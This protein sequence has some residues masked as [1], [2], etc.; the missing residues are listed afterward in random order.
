MNTVQSIEDELQQR[1]VLQFKQKLAYGIGH[2]LNDVCASMWFTYLL[3]YYEKILL[4]SATNAGLVLLIGQ[5]ADALATPFVGLHSDIED[6]FW[7]CQYGKRKTW[8]LIGTVCV[9]GTFPFMFSQC[10]GC[11]MSHQWAQLVYYTVFVCI[12]QFGWAAVQISHLS[13]IPELTALEKER[14]ALI[15]IRYT[16]TVFSNVLVYSVTWAVLHITSL[17]TTILFHMF[18]KEYSRSS[19][20]STTGASREQSQRQPSSPVSILKNRELYRLALIY[21]PSRLFV[22]LVQS[23][24]PFYLQDTLHMAATSLAV[25]PLIMY[26]S[27]FKVSFT[28]HCINAKVGRLVSYT[29]GASMGLGACGWIYFGN[30]DR[31]ESLFIYPVSMLL[32][33]GGSMMLVTSLAIIADYIG[34]N[35]E[36]GAFIYGLMSFT[37]KLSNGIAVLL[38]QYMRCTNARSCEYYYKDI[39]VFVCGGSAMVGLMVTFGSRACHRSRVTSVIDYDHLDSEEAGR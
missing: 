38:I 3:V 36:N 29:I 18:I 23:Y 2:I 12:F 24:V 11:Q 37:D 33:G 16:F 32:G 5:V 15:A 17:L 19:R 20:L 6:N 26:L 9:L 7:L 10:L 35:T 30:V 4:F 31:I 13:L 14:T 27:S 21:M 25:I 8:H 39:L 34:Q 28:I 1:P 22:N